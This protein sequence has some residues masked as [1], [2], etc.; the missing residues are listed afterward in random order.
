M[1]QVKD[2]SVLLEPQIRA[3]IE[4]LQEPLQSL[5]GRLERNMGS[6]FSES[7]PDAGSFTRDFN[8]ITLFSG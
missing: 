7:K 3:S 1:K 8:A 4:D 5:V 6:I 2:H